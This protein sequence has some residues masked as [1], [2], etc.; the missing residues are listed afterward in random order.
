M[1][2]A[3]GY[4]LSWFD[5]LNNKRSPSEYTFIDGAHLFATQYVALAFLLY[6]Y[7]P[8]S[9]DS[10]NWPNVLFAEVIFVNGRDI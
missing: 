1:A 6:I 8:A 5:L 3:H 10:L 4:K 7:S 2:L 9:V